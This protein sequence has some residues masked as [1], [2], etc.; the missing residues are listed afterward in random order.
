MP[1]ISKF[2]WDIEKKAKEHEVQLSQMSQSFDPLS[3]SLSSHE[4]QVISFLEKITSLS[5]EKEKIIIRVCELRSL[6][7]RK[8]DIMLSGLEDSQSAMKSIEPANLK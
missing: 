8:F 7:T 5:Q 3:V 2:I 1:N 4:D 6:T